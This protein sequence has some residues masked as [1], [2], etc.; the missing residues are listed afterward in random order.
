MRVNVGPLLRSAAT[1][2]CLAFRENLQS[3]LHKTSLLLKSSCSSIVGSRRNG[4][5]PD[6]EAQSW[7]AKSVRNEQHLDEFEIRD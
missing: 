2:F 3:D 1:R 5:R 7:S 6:Q 4:A